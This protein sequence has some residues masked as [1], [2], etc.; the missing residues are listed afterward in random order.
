[1]LIS[2]EKSLSQKTYLV[3][4]SDTFR[5][6]PQ[7]PDGLCALQNGLLPF[8]KI[9]TSCRNSLGKG[10]FSKSFITFYSK[11]SLGKRYKKT[12]LKRL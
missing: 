2:I 12:L 3:M 4:F 7:L 11:K 6:S 10:F 9:S 8:A 5:T 1:M